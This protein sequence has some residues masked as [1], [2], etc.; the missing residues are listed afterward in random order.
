MFISGDDLLEFHQAVVSTLRDADD[1][2]LPLDPAP[3][4]PIQPNNPLLTHTSEDMARLSE[5]HNDLG[6]DQHEDEAD[7]GKNYSNHISKT[8]QTKYKNVIKNPIKKRTNK[9]RHSTCL[10]ITYVCVCVIPM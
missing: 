1:V 6:P 10:I 8:N 3:L 9:K 4:P 5:T 2:P 7:T